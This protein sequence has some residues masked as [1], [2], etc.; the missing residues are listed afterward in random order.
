MDKGY[1]TNLE[2]AIERQ[3]RVEV[4]ERDIDLMD[5]QIEAKAEEYAG[6]LVKKIRY[7]LGMVQIA[8]R[9]KREEEETC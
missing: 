5:I 7:D 9:R 8:D 4:A 2:I 6:E 1:K 3:I